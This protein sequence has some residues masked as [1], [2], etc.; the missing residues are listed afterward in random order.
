MIGKLTRQLY[1]TDIKTSLAYL[2]AAQNLASTDEIRA[3]PSLKTTRVASLYQL[4]SVLL[5]ICVELVSNL[6][7]TLFNQLKVNSDDIF[8]S[9]N[10]FTLSYSERVDDNRLT[11]DDFLAISES[12]E[13]TGYLRK[14]SDFQNVL[15][16]I[17]KIMKYSFWKLRECRKLDNFEAFS[18]YRISDVIFRLSSIKSDV[19]LLLSDPP[20]KNESSAFDILSDWLYSVASAFQLPDLSPKEAQLELR[21]LFDKRRQQIV[22]I[23]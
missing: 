12:Q 15:Q 1:K 9:L 22:G 11:L 17:L 16:R 20:S 5:K 21:K 6:C 7:A 8:V 2:I 19:K 10:T 13:S 4:H 18:V 23:W 3:I 14:V